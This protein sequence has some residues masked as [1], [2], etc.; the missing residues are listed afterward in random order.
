M[1]EHLGL[2]K[3]H[4]HGEQ[5]GGKK[6]KKKRNLLKK[7]KILGWPTSHGP[8]VTKKKKKETREKEKE[9]KKRKK[10]IRENKRKKKEKRISRHFTSTWSFLDEKR[11]LLEAMDG[12]E[13]E[14][15]DP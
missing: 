4:Y 6:K 12:E 15:E 3:P 13:G 1:Y 7:K 2:H 8:R 10:K 11:D 14:L 9:E 5:K